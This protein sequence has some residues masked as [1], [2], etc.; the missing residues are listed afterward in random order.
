MASRSERH[1]INVEDRSGSIDYGPF[2]SHQAA[3]DFLSS[4]GWRKFHL[5]CPSFYPPSQSQYDK[6]DGVRNAIVYQRKHP[7]LKAPEKFPD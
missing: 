4:K 6:R 3:L 2:A 5:M 7:P 1:Y